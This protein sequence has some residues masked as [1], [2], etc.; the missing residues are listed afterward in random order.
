MVAALG[1]IA[2]P[3]R[4][5]LGGA[6]IVG[7][8]LEGPFLSPARAGT[9]PRR[10]PARARPALLERL[11]DAGPVRTV[12][13]APE[14]PGAL[15]LIELCTRPGVAVWLGHSEATPRGRRRVRC[16][17]ALRSRTSS[18][19]WPDQRP[20]AGARRCRARNAG[21]RHPADRR[22]RP[23][24]RRAAARCLRGGA[25]ALQPGHRRRRRRGASG[26]H[27]PAR[28]DRDRGLGRRRAP[29]RRRARRQHRPPRRRPRP[30]RRARARPG[31]GGRR[32]DGAARPAARRRDRATRA[33]RPRRPAD[34]RRAARPRQVLAAGR[35][36][37][38]AAR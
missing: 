10:A 38:E 35:R 29:R 18:T 17:R 26:R 15:E 9:H 30:A 36:L 3:G 33:G 16:R 5:S 19:R 34:R 14:L 23:R 6:R 31:R 20:R 28:R 12:T 8:H 21:R 27:L 22:R 32:G 4:G 11:L 1:R 7:V 2:E 25:R 37:E 24:L 13:L